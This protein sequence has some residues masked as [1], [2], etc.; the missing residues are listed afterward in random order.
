MTPMKFAGNNGPRPSG[1]KVTIFAVLVLEKEAVD[2][3]VSKQ[4]EL[5]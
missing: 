3:T 2:E 5:F 1:L 4:E